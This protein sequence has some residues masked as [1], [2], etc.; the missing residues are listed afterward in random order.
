MADEKKGKSLREI[1]M[2]FE[3]LLAFAIHAATDDGRYSNIEVTE[4][5]ISMLKGMANALCT[6]AYIGGMTKDTFID[7]V[8]A[9]WDTARIAAD[10]AAD[11]ID[12]YLKKVRSQADEVEKQC[13]C[14]DCASS[15][16]NEKKPL[17]N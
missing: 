4:I 15:V 6:L 2:D 17:K 1:E 7:A 10:E 12:E 11:Q 8:T 3:R 16:L 5:E 13:D 14:S 9:T